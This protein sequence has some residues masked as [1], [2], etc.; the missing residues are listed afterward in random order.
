MG[1]ESINNSDKALPEQVA[2]RIVEIIANGEFDKGDKLPNEFRLAEE[3][4]VGRGTIREAMKILVSKNV[5]EIRR[6]MGT[7]VADK[8]GIV[9]DPL[10]LTF[11]KDKDRLALDLCELRIILE[12]EIAAMA[13]QRATD[14]DLRQIEKACNEVE[15]CIREGEDYSEAD[16]AFHERI[17][18]SSK[19]Q[20]VPN[21]IPVIQSAIE[22][23]I[24]VTDAKMTAQTIET[25]RL[26]VDAIKARDPERARREMVG[27]LEYNRDFIEAQYQE[28]HPK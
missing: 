23:F 19:N 7:Y 26:I 10:G 27:H 4:N 12:P 24:V 28:R 18:K 11:I 16:V 8:P 17:A 13:A 15:R 20:V 1:L 25:H 2:D 21:V 3:L 5:V 6:G 9:D 22:I 14:H